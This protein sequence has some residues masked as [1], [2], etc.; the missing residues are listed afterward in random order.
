MIDSTPTTIVVLA[1]ERLSD[2]R[3][4]IGAL[5]TADTGKH[6]AIQQ[7]WGGTGKPDLLVVFSATPTSGGSS[8]ITA[9]ADAAQLRDVPV[10]YVFDPA[11]D[12][13]DQAP[14]CLHLINGFPLSV[15]RPQVGLA[16]LILR[17]TGVDERERRV[18]LSY[19]RTHGQR[20]AK[21]LRRRLSDE[22]WSVFI[23]KFNI[24]PG[25]NFQKELFRDMDGRSLLLVIE[26]PET[27]E[28]RWVDDEIAFAHTHGIGMQALKLPS[29][30][31]NASVLDRFPSSLSIQLTAEQTKGSPTNPKL[32]S[33][34][35]KD[36]VGKLQSVHTRTYQMR[37]ED[38]LYSATA[39]MQN[40]G[41]TVTAGPEETLIGSPDP[42][43]SADPSEWVV[44]VTV[45]RPSLRD[46]HRIRA[47]MDARAGQG[48]LR[49][50]LVH[51]VVDP[52]DGYFATLEWLAGPHNIEVMPVSMFASRV[53]R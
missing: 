11:L 39:M 1:E 13:K 29:V 46:L 26:S 52:D 42:K 4:L 34:H 49:G 19:K 20:M 9:A 30:S 28:S 43:K 12:F 53:S 27:R 16:S 17:L 3:S 8:L 41:L 50:Y 24:E 48:S 10:I 32:R 15:G 23:D 33:T 40:L 31:S 38:L 2:A 44:A 14:E 47:G 21:Q 7:S 37:R 36:L 22:G 45:R 25:A 5:E 18:F 51:R 6:L 35:V